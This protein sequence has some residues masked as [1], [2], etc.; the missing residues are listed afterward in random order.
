M[1]KMHRDLGFQDA[2]GQSALH[3]LIDRVASAPDKCCHS[4]CHADMTPMSHNLAL[5]CN[6]LS[7]LERA[8]VAWVEPVGHMD[9]APSEVR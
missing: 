5:A 8:I 4:V 7:G 3:T 2:D 9:G 1:Q 6:A